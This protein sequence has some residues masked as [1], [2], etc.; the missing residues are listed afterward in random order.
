MSE[1]ANIA[2][3]IGTG[4]AVWGSLSRILTRA[5]RRQIVE[6]LTKGESQLLALI[7]GAFAAALATILVLVVQHTQDLAS[8]NQAAHSVELYGAGLTAALRELF[9]H[10]GLHWPPGS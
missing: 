3:I 5:R 4:I 6:T 1:L 10:L 7:G 9:E 2:T 8:F